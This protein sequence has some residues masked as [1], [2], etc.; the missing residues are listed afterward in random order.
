MFDK[1]PF[2]VTLVLPVLLVAGLEQW[3]VPFTARVTR[4][5]MSTGL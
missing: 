1:V 2:R 3:A 5:S 4:G